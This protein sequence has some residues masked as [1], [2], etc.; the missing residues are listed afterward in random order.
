MGRERAQGSLGRKP[1]NRHVTRVTLAFFNAPV[2]APAALAPLIPRKAQ[3]DF[4]FSALRV[5]AKPDR[6]LG[7]LGK[8]FIHF[9]LVGEQLLEAGGLLDCLPMG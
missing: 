7:R 4:C 8:L 2:G 1:R 3:R 9:F 5:S 6:R